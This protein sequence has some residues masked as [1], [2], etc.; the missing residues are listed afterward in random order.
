MVNVGPQKCVP[1]GGEKKS[2]VQDRQLS[3]HNDCHMSKD[4]K[5]LKWT[6]AVLC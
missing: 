2:V 5:P 3:T 4:F 1:W 6:W